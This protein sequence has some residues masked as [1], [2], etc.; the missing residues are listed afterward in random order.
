VLAA[1]GGGRWRLGDG[2]NL[3]AC[4]RGQWDEVLSAPHGVIAWRRQARRDARVHGRRPRRRHRLLPTIDDSLDVSADA[5]L[6]DPVDGEFSTAVATHMQ[7]LVGGSAIALLWLLESDLRATQCGALS[8]P[9]PTTWN[10]RSG[11]WRHNFSV[12]MACLTA[13]TTRITSTR[14]ST[15]LVYHCNDAISRTQEGHRP[16]CTQARSLSARNGEDSSDRPRCPRLKVSA[17]R[18]G[19]SSNMIGWRWL[20]LP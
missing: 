3:W 6:V 15:R 16:W 17:L 18:Q 10:G 4:R 12:R 19:V 5:M 2:I 8:K 1:G 9:Q 14:P 7:A 13:K 20:L 11:I